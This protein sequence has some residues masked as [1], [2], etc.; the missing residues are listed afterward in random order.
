MSVLGTVRASGGLVGRAAASKVG[1][2]A[3]VSNPGVNN[4]IVGLDL[5]LTLAVL[6]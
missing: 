6:S 1:G 2:G 3:L 4:L 5:P